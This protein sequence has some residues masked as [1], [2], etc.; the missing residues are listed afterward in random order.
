MLLNKWLDF[1]TS[2]LTEEGIA[3][4]SPAAAAASKL[5]K[6]DMSLTQIY[7]QVKIQWTSE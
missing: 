1:F 7:A 3:Q 2:G 4:L 6:S 5:I